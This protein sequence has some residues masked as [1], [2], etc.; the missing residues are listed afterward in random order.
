MSLHSRQNG[1]PLPRKKEKEMIM[2]HTSRSLLLA[3]VLTS[4]GLTAVLLT[5]C[6]N[7]EHDYLLAV[8]QLNGQIAQISPQLPMQL[9]SYTQLSS[10]SY[11]K[12]RRQI[13]YGYTIAN[14]MAR[15]LT[16][17]GREEIHDG[18]LHSLHAQ[19]PESREF[20]N[21]MQ[22]FG[23]I[24]HYSYTDADGHPLFS[25]TITPEEVLTG[26]STGA[27]VL[28]ETKAV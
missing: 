1:I 19:L 21:S 28:P 18:I 5:A 27:V 15:I 6:N 3:L 23:I 8:R 9:N 11:D 26:V 7:S 2:R 16:A 20:T 24:Y 10:M 13:R 22:R 14:D 12:E 17:E 4:L 25:F